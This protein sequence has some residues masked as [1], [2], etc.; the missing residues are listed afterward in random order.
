MWNMKHEKRLDSE[1]LQSLN[2]IYYCAYDWRWH[3]LPNRLVLFRCCCFYPVAYIYFLWIV[4]WCLLGSVY[5]NHIAYHVDIINTSRH[6]PFSRVLD[7]VYLVQ[8]LGIS[9]PNLAENGTKIELPATQHA[10]L[11]TIQTTSEIGK[12]RSQRTHTHSHIRM[13]ACA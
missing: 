11:V 1:D 7:V 5:M 13:S 12:T 2:S 10:Y 6:L 4:D 9:I 8:F 3:I